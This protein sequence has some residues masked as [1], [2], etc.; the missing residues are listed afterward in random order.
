MVLSMKILKNKI[1]LIVCFSVVVLGLA[2]AFVFVSK[3]VIEFNTEKNGKIEVYSKDEVLPPS[4][5]LSIANLKLPIKL[6]T[7][8][9]INPNKVG[10]YQ[11]TYE[12]V[13]LWKKE[14]KTFDVAVVDTVPPVIEVDDLNF[15][16]NYADKAPTPEEIEVGFVATD[17][18]DGDITANV[19]KE[20]DGRTCVLSV[21]D[22]SGNIA[23]AEI[24]IVYKDGASP[25]INLV[26]GDV[27]CHFA[28][29]EYSDPGFSASDNVDGDITSAVAVSGTVDA[30]KS[31]EYLVE[32]SVTDSSGNTSKR[33]RKVIVYGT[34]GAD[35]LAGVI[36]NGKTVYL[37]FDDGPGAYTEKLLEYLDRYGVKATFFVTGQFPK[38]QHLIGKAHEKGHKIALHTLT[39][40]WSIYS[41]VDSFMADFEGAQNI[42]AAQTGSRT[43]IFRFPGGTNNTISRGYKKGI[44]SEL[45]NKLAGE[46][47]AYFDW[48]CD[49]ND[50]RYNN[51]GLVASSTI[52][53][54]SKRQN[55]VV[56][57]HDIKSHTVEAIPAIIEYCLRN[58]YTFKVL[59][60]DA[61]AVR[62]NPAN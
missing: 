24:N 28:G 1:I 52:S 59:D 5:Y 33:T 26:G 7:E 31:G 44:M 18:Y 39:H 10:K 57:M 12:A 34:L 30:T 2:A 53:Q 14:K 17:N 56:L 54:I 25:K 51:A 11:H 4:A 38:Y 8:G 36:S 62:F 19:T 32:Y 48:N 6:K 35:E 61:P 22:S 13:F 41:S 60:K 16:Y 23:K 46:G 45:A 21:S 50:T 9:E 43:D 37:T 55:S 27:V 42:I 40:K 58:G 49:S 3:P 15:T 20:I 29:N 47:Y